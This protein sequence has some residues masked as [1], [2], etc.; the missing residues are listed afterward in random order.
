MQ[1]DLKRVLDA[2][3][4][5]ADPKAAVLRSV[6]V[7]DGR[8]VAGGVGFE[9]DRVL[10]LAAGKAACAMARAAEEL[11][12]ERISGGLV[13]TKEGHEGRLEHLQTISASHPEPDECGAEAARRVVELTESLEEGDLLLALV[14]G[15]ASA[16]L[17]D[18]DPSIGLEDLKQLTG[19]LLRS[20]AAI[21]EINA[22]RK[23]V[24]EL[25]GGGLA[26]RAAPATVLA[27]LL[28]DVVGDDPSSIASGLTSP[29]PT[30]L[31]DVRE[32]VERYDLDLPQ[33]VARHL[34]GA[35]ETP[36][37]GDPV[38]EK[39]A[40]VLVGGGRAT[41]EAAAER[42][43]ELG[44]A[45]LIIS[46]YIAGEM[47]S[48]GLHAAIVREVLD[49]GNPVPPPCA[50]VSGGG[51]TVAV[52]GNGTGGP[53]QEFALALAL[54]LEGVEGWAAF[55]ADTDG[56]DGP[57]DAAG[58]MVDGTTARAIRGGGADPRKALERNDAYE[59][60]SAGNALLL[61]GPTGTNVNDLRV[62]LVDYAVEKGHVSVREGWSR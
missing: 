14:S 28:S 2:G 18:P 11:L 39:V 16:L 22:I 27:L 40:N 41:A 61:T 1:E 49:S 31:K 42:A 17:A 45:P 37:P 57:T 15:G 3:L 21:D 6:R 43:R 34:E 25:K 50:I 8:I 32:I 51:S 23:H 53:N 30:T 4:A 5:A 35:P 20:G 7:E 33:S 60:L 59:A 38:F 52:R 24:S 56:G 12:G 46:T 26:R 62:A 44:Y 48:A 47:R 36:K 13:I 55:A 9:F 58:G 29:D 54:E 10:V 19:A